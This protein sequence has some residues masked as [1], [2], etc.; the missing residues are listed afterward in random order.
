MKVQP[1]LVA[2]VVGLWSLFPILEQRMGHAQEGDAT[3][4]HEH[5]A[6]RE[7]SVVPPEPPREQMGGHFHHHRPPILPPEE[8]KAYSELNHRAAGVLVLLAGGCALLATVGGER[9]AWARHGWPGLF[10]LLGIFL[11]I[12]HDPESWPWGPLTF[13]E[14]VT[15]AQVLQHTLFTLVVFAIGIIEWLRSRAIL[16]HPGWGWIFPSLAISAAL[17]LF[18]H[19][20][21]EGPVANKIYRHHAIMATAG[22]LSMMAKIFDDAQL[23]K[24]RVSAYLWTTLIMFVGFL[25]LIYT[26]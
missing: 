21:G 16:T 19:K 18:M 1:V 12:R 6:A 4:R 9:Y 7:E 23:F 26:E 14:S 13:W 3:E 2:G 10:F 24:S 15:D 11:T 25:L 8:D 20:H 5:H 17:M 22:I